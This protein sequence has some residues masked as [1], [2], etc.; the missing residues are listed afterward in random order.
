MTER[1]KIGRPLSKWKKKLLILRDIN[2]NEIT[3]SQL[4]EITGVS[5]DYLSQVLSRIVR[6]KRQE[7]IYDTQDIY[8]A[9]HAET[10]RTT[11]GEGQD[12]KIHE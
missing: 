5:R 2:S 3:L 7:T 10:S 12:N 8:E 9:I 4:E 1:S 6:R 11:K